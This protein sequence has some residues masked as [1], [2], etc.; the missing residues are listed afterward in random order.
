MA[1]SPGLP[2]PGSTGLSSSSNTLQWSPSTNLAVST[3]TPLLM[4]DRPMPIPSDDEKRSDSTAWGMCSNNPC[5]TSCDHI[6]PDDI[7]TVTEDTSQRPGQA[8]SAFRI[9]LPKASPTITT[10]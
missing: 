3:P 7:I 8:L 5:L 1:T 4:S 2:E 6:T 9:G 10:L